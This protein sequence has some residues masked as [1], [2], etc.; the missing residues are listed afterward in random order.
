MAVVSVVI[1]TYNRSDL[2]CE[3]IDSVL[4][5]TLQ[6]TEI[7]VV[8]D[9]S[10]DGT[11]RILAERYGDQI[12][13]VFQPNQGRSVARN[14]GAQAT[15]GRY[16]TFLDSDDLLLPHAS[17]TLSGMLDQE[18][19]V[20][21]AYADGYYCDSSGSVIEPFSLGTPMPSGD[22]LETLMST[23]IVVAPAAGMI[24]R[25]WLER[26]GWP[27]FDESLRGTEDHDFWLR[28]A[29][30]GCPF[31]YVDKII[32]KYRL[33]GGNESSPNSPNRARR[34]ESLRRGL[35][36]MLNAD[37][38]SRVSVSV[39]K[40]VLWRMLSLVWV[41]EPKSQEEILCH[42]HF[43]ELPA[44]TRASL[45]YRVGIDNIIG[46]KEM[47]VGQR[48]L[49]MAAQLEPRNSKYR[50]MAVLSRLG[51]GP[52]GSVVALRRCFGRLFAGAERDRDIAPHWRHEPSGSAPGR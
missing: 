37:Y 47:A 4:A 33:H 19:S 41:D 28:L 1:P 49:R 45:L 23:A 8:D 34:R 43:L 5:Q 42:P 26:M 50:V 6:G 20:G 29:A 36:K 24:R 7:V 27:L 40:G 11:G 30:L 10:T 16:V 15:T 46:L 12:H 39:R 9:G 14:R 2:V 3:A 22:V 35:R 17:E 18:P 38:F 25:S 13:Y 48:R 32:C 21:V 52:I 31:R 44:K 51:P